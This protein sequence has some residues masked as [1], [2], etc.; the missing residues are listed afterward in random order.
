MNVVVDGL[1]LLEGERK[2]TFDQLTAQVVRVEIMTKQRWEEER[3]RSEEKERVMTNRCL[4]LEKEMERMKDEMERMKMKMEKI[5]VT[6]SGGE[7]SVRSLSFFIL[8]SFPSFLFHLFLLLTFFS[9]PFLSFPF[10]F[11]L[12]FSFP[13]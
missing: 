13:D 8:S 12:F 11:Y 6:G 1:K 2:T 3:R 7:M 9:F 10:L 5:R 4:N